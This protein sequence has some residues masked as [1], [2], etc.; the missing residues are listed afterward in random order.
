[1]STIALVD[2]GCVLPEGGNSKLRHVLAPMLTIR[3]CKML[4]SV[5]LLDH[6]GLKC[7]DDDLSN[8]WVDFW[9]AIDRLNRDAKGSVV[10]KVV[11]LAR[12]AEGLRE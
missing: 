11:F 7:D 10:Y 2:F 8:R 9:K 5:Q 3:Y 1:M 12:H 6:F 4:T